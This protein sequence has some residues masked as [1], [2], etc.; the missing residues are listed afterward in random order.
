MS[1]QIRSIPE[2]DIQNA[3]K[4]DITLRRRKS[5]LSPDSPFVVVRKCPLFVIQF[6]RLQ[7]NRGNWVA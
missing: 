6:E 2:A 1:A 3:P 4:Q 5:A 7:V